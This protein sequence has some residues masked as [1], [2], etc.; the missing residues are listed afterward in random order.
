MII[1]SKILPFDLS[2]RR[3]R[4]VAMSFAIELLEMIY[5]AED[6]YKE[7]LPLH[8]HGSKSYAVADGAIVI[9]DA[10]NILWSVYNE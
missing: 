3:K 1:N 4:R 8:L 9:I 6:N 2:T 5:R 7:N 10:V